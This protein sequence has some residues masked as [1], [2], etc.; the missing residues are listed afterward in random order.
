MVVGDINDIGEVVG[1]YQ[2][3]TLAAAY[4]PF[5]FDINSGN[6]VATNLNGLEFD[7][8]PDP[9]G[10]PQSDYRIPEGWYIDSAWDINR[11][12]Q[13]AGAIGK[14]DDPEYIR[15]CVIELYPDPAD[16]LAL[17]RL[18]LIPEPE[19]WTHTYCR[20]IN[21]NGVVL[22]GDTRNG[23]D[24]TYVYRVGDADIQ[25]IPVPFN[26]WDDNPHLTNPPVGESSFVKVVLDQQMW[27]Y[28]VETKEM[29]P[30]PMPFA[31]DDYYRVYR[32][33][34]GGNFCGIYDTAGKGNKSTRNGYVFD[35]TFHLLEDMYS[36][37][38]INNDR[39]VLG[40]RPV[41]DVGMRMQL[42][43]EVHGSISIDATIVAADPV[44]EELWAS[45]RMRGLVITERDASGFPMLAGDIRDSSVSNFA[46]GFVLIPIPVP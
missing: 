27:N 40:Q 20:R 35:G 10:Q 3:P 16:P 22:G 24:I 12:G 29:T 30:T 19:E 39:D 36:A 45:G 13:I 18:H 23:F 25:E 41:R 2:H 11:W 43:H 17:P 14:L 32:I 34:D 37:E 31:Q 28:E 9:E 42:D 38:R 1:S 44:E 7:P 21:D 6:T 4:L 8:G 15:G 46:D 26:M 5:Y 33:N